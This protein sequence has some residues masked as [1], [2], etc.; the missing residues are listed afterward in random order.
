M[1]I[2]L[3]SGITIIDLVVQGNTSSI[4][5]ANSIKGNQFKS[6]KREQRQ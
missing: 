5:K 2:E 3:R 6:V 4:W 1:Y